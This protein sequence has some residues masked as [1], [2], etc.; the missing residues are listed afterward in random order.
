MSSFLQAE[1]EVINSKVLRPK[2]LSDNQNMHELLISSFR[3]VRLRTR[4]LLGLGVIRR[5]AL[6]KSDATGYMLIKERQRLQ[7]DVF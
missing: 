6:V 1:S 2:V 7:C 3:H 4:R 5:R